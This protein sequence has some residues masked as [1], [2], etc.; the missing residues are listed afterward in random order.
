M[1][2]RRKE[3]Q[4]RSG[5]RPLPV[6]LP[7]DDDWNNGYTG[8]DWSPSDPNKGVLCTTKYYP[9]QTKSDNTVKYCE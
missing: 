5:R 9:C 8:G 2:E 4:T 3:P 6:M 7:S 1:P